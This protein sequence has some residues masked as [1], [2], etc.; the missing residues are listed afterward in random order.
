MNFATAV[1]TTL[2]VACVSFLWFA[3]RSPTT[4]SHQR[5]MRATALAAGFVY[6]LIAAVFSIERVNRL[7]HTAAAAARPVAARAAG[8]AQ[9]GAR[10]TAAVARAGEQVQPLLARAHEAVGRPA[11]RAPT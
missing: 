8:V 11:A 4:A 2:Q 9:A 3:A 1:A 6:A 10:A 5:K 7:A